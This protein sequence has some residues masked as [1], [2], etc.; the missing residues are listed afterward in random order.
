MTPGGQS[1]ELHWSTPGTT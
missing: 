1:Q